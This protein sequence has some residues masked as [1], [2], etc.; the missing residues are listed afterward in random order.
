M[1]FSH[2]S[3]S[4]GAYLATAG[5]TP[6]RKCKLIGHTFEQVTQLYAHLQPEHLHNQVAR[7]PQISSKAILKFS[8]TAT[9]SEP[10]RQRS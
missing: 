1:T 4:F 3:G 6:L 7:I 5:V 9:Y 2:G 10:G 8:Q